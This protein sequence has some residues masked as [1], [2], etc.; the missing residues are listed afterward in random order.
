M[1]YQDEET[2]KT[3]G[4]VIIGLMVGSVAIGILLFFYLVIKIL[5]V[6]SL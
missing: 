3:I 2:P 5:K 6:L 1:Q 4:E